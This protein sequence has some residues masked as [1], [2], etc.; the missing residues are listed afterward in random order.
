[1]VVDGTT[2][3]AVFEPSVAHFL[4]PPLRPGQGV[5]LDNLSAHKGPRVR[6]WIAAC[7]C[8]GWYVPASS[9]DL[10]P[11]EAAFAKLKASL[12]RAAARTK[13]AWVDALA[14]ALPHITAADAR[15]FFTHCGDTC[16]KSLDQ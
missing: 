2:D 9:P 12:R 4:V 16:R 8:A 15:G 1:M 11:S 13:A 3:T 6:Q 5:V 14:V 7:G 10:S